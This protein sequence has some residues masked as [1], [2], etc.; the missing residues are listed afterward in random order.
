LKYFPNFAQA[1]GISWFEK[2]DVIAS[3]CSL[4]LAF[5]FFVLLL[6]VGIILPVYFSYFRFQGPMFFMPLSFNGAGLQLALQISGNLFW[7]W[8]F[9]SLLALVTISPILPALISLAQEP[10]RK[11]R[12]IIMHTFIFYAMNIVSS[13]N[14][15]AYLI[16]RNAGFPITAKEE[17]I[18]KNK[19]KS[20]IQFLTLP[21][22]NR[23]ETVLIEMIFAIV[24]LALSIATDNI[25]FVTFGS[26]LIAGVMLFKWG[27][28]N[29][30]VKHLVAVPF[31][32]L[33]L[34]FVFI[35]KTLQ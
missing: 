24:F 8:D 1:K 26:G 20:I 6:L 12:Y 30:L 22:S 11:I 5:P 33:V 19:D 15:C 13:L 32:V 9:F 18:D 16:T 31:W 21:L 7:T 27:L 17:D 3:A 35:M 14:L 4:L 10:S 2:F 25:W 29:R 34:I 28:N 23:K